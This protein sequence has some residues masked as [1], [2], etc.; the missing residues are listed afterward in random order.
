MYLCCQLLEKHKDFCGLKKKKKKKERVCVCAA[1]G[2]RQHRGEFIR[3]ASSL[4][5]GKGKGESPRHC[6]PG[7]SATQGTWL[8][9]S[10]WCLHPPF[11]PSHVPSY[12]KVAIPP[13]I[14]P[15]RAAEPTGSSWTYSSF[16]LPFFH[17]SKIK[18]KTN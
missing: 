13:K 15:Q 4:N 11:V 17:N 8:L 14:D 12:L 2:G 16:L 5:G 18:N 6:L 10:A 7:H 3:V 1:G 9:L